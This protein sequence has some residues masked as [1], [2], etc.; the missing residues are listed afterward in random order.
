M[1]VPGTT[2][3]SQEA[4][5]ASSIAPA[6]GPAPET[7]WDLIEAIW[8]QIPDEEFEKLPPDGS[9][10]HDHYIYSVPKRAS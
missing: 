9:A 10:Q 7:D 5:T 2:D 6:G 8:S 3:Q 4:A 1:S